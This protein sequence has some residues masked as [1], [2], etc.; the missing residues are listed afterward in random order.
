MRHSDKLHC[1][2][3]SFSEVE[4]RTVSPFRQQSIESSEGMQVDRCTLPQPPR[5]AALASF[6]GQ[7][8]G[9]QT[10]TRSNNTFGSL[11]NASATGAV[12]GTG[13]TIDLGAGGFT[14]L[15]AKYD[16]QNDLSFVWNVADLGGIITIPALGPL[17]HGLSGWILFGGGQGVSDGGTTGMLLSAA[18]GA[19]GMARRFL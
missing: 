15:F 17:G 8:Q 7:P 16:G 13:T 1:V 10:V 5:F 18:L 9:L 3:F 6:S 14:Y 11:H 2:G 4:W 19:L 12:S